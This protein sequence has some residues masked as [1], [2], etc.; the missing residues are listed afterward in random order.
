MPKRIIFSCLIIAAMTML[1]NMGTSTG[2]A[3]GSN[4]GSTGAP[5]DNSIV[6]GHPACHSDNSFG[7]TTQT[8]ELIDP[9]TRNLI[10]HYVPG[11]LYDARVNVISG[12]GTGRY[13]FQATALDTGLITAGTWLNP[14]GNVQISQAPD[15]MNR[16]RTYV[17]HEMPH[18]LSSFSMQ[19]RAP[20]CN[21][22]PVKFYY[23]GNKV[24]NNNAPSG[25][26]GG[27][28]DSTLIEPYVINDLVLDQIPIIPDYY[29]AENL[30]EVTGKIFSPDSV[31]LSSGNSIILSSPFE[32]FSGAKLTVNIEDCN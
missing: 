20:V 13:G 10:T 1:F 25:D 32:I 11:K 4:S 21:I 26:S 28:G 23:S 5:C 24:N 15:C 18:F 12:A 29:W 8:L 2:R 31:S 14:G 19:W 30:I 7:L 17:E 9:V 16:V 6:C 3:N 27:L 22:G